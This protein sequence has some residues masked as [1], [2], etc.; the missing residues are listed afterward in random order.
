MDGQEVV[1]F[2]LPENAFN[3]L[4]QAVEDAALVLIPDE[5]NHPV[6][7]LAERAKV[8][9]QA[10][11]VG[12]LTLHVS[13]TLQRSKGEDMKPVLWE[14]TIAEVVPY[15]P[16]LTQQ[17]ELDEA[18]QALAEE[19]EEALRVVD[20]VMV[21]YESDDEIEDWLWFWRRFTLD[22]R[23]RTVTLTRGTSIVTPNGEVEIPEIPRRRQRPD[24][25]WSH[26]LRLLQAGGSDDYT[27]AVR[28]LCTVVAELSAD[29]PDE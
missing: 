20:E 4:A 1:T 26:T 7:Q 11:R 21:D 17:P 27:A 29:E 24:D 16:A 19:V 25:L 10:W 23:Q 5:L 12:M 14:A 8:T 13:V 3:D 28:D 18:E 22:V 9:S 2:G 15:E 6:L